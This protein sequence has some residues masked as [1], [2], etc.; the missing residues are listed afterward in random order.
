MSGNGSGS[1]ERTDVLVIGSGFGG[2]IAAYHLAA[3]GA[4]VVVLERGPWLQGEDFDHDY[5]MGK[6]YTRAFDFVSGDGMSILGGNC[7][8]GGS[9]VYFATMP[10]APRF[11]FE[12]RGS[13]G[14]RMW[15]ASITRDSL[16][17]WYDRVAEALPITKQTWDK[18]PYAG[19]L[20]AAACA[21]AGRT[22]NP[23]PSAV[24]L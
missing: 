9:V 10:R 20:F 2:A 8:G 19:G 7:V 14:R 6:S 1:V 12:R 24:D 16:E 21:H 5:L 4:N 13:I 18:V 3:G 17:P 23:S 15:P 22:A 11:V